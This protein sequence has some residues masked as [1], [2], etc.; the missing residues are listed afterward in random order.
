[1][2][3]KIE[4]L[5]S[6]ESA[7]VLRVCG[8]VQAEHM[9]TIEELI[10]G[11]SGG[12]ALDLVEVTIVDRDAVTLLADTER[13]GVQLRNC[14]AFLREWISSE[15]QRVAAENPHRPSDAIIDGEDL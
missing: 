5:K 1:M 2:T 6:D 11:E 9:R 3:C 14:P 13:N 8:R 4:R 15:H 10:G 12:V 7:I